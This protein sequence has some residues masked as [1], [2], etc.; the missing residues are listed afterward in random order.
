MM[1]VSGIQGIGPTT[2]PQ[3]HIFGLC[4]SFCKLMLM[5]DIKS[6]EMFHY[7]FVLGL[8]ALFAVQRSK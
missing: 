4:P 6:I 8:G 1:S 2:Q 3:T 5:H 7:A